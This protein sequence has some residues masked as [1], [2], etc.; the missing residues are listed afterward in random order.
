MNAELLIS[1]PQTLDSMVSFYRSL[2]LGDTTL[3]LLNLGEILLFVFE[4]ICMAP[5]EAYITMGHWWCTELLSSPLQ[6]KHSFPQLLQNT[7]RWWLSTE[8]LFQNYLQQRKSSYVK[9]MPP[10]WNR[11]HPMTGKHGYIKT[12]DEYNLKALWALEYPEEASEAFFKHFISLP[13]PIFLPSHPHRCWSSEHFGLHLPQNLSCIVTLYVL[14]WKAQS[15][16]LSI[17]ISFFLSYL[18]Q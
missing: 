4:H 14:F 8:S 3:S 18:R 7:D 17:P 6:R 12:Q 16:A 2:L 5:I 9:A 10:P 15:K 13:C 11:P 1:S